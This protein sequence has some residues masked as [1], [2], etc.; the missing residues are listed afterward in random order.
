[1]YLTLHKLFMSSFILHFDLYKTDEKI[2]LRILI[3]IIANNLK[4]F[5]ILSQNYTKIINYMA[6]VITNY[7]MWLLYKVDNL[8]MFHICEM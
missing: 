6:A 1:M 8:L 4:I 3:K 5:R 7:N 2:S